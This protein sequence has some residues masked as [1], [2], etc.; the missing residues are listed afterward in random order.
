MSIAGHLATLVVL[1]GRLLGREDGKSR[2]R[3][4]T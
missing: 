3:S 2:S 4:K 1:L